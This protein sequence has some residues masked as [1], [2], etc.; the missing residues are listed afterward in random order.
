VS[1]HGTKLSTST[2]LL[3]SVVFRRD[4]APVME[5]L[6]VQ[7]LEVMK[8]LKS[9]SARGSK[10]DKDS[11]RNFSST[12]FKRRLRVEGSVDDWSF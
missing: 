5:S 7:R 11:V 10:K 3:I 8:D 6:T 2:N 9:A 12:H 1:N 4:P